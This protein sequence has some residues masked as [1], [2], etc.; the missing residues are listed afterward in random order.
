MPSSGSFPVLVYRYLYIASTRIKQQ[1]G[2]HIMLFSSRGH[3]VSVLALCA[4]RNSPHWHPEK[5]KSANV[6][7][8]SLSINSIPATMVAN[9]ELFAFVCASQTAINIT[10]TLGPCSDHTIISIFAHEESIVLLAVFS[11]WAGRIWR[12]HRQTFH[13]RGD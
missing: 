13:S 4:N 2:V 5:M 8:R 9:T 3:N 10:T 6:S 11:F 7:L 1:R 12:Q